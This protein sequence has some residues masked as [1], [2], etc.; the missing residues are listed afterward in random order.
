[1][2]IFIDMSNGRTKNYHEIEKTSTA[3]VA[4]LVLRSRRYWPT[5]F[6][7]SGKVKGWTKNG[8][9]IPQPCLLCP[10][11]DTSPSRRSSPTSDTPIS[12]ARR[13]PRPVLE[14]YAADLGIF[15]LTVFC[16][17][18]FFFLYFPPHTSLKWHWRCSWRQRYSGKRTPTDAPPPSSNIKSG[19][20]PE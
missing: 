18:D 20:R 8:V 15:E 6:V 5:N 4:R 12:L 13:V 10:P 9:H 14:Y 1:M 11:T 7:T 17:F 16:I 19:I 3:T 2:L